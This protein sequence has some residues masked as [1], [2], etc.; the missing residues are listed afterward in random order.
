MAM[1]AEMDHEVQMARSDLFKIAKYAVELHD[2]LKSVS[3][4]EGLEG[5][6]QSKITKAA[7]YL[8]SVYHS[9]D[10]EVNVNESEQLE[11]NPLRIAKAVEA[12]FGKLSK[13]MKKA[14]KLL[15]LLTKASRPH[16]LV[17]KLL[18]HTRVLLRFKAKWLTIQEKLKEYLVKQVLVSK[19]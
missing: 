9:M 13:F 10:Y 5:W 11:E 19:V 2:M 15:K 4:A 6:Q 18:G 8:G 17:A 3:E 14:K 7:D 1:K 12:G 16:S